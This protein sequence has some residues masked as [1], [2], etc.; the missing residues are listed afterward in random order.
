[1]KKDGGR[2][3]ER[4]RGREGVMEIYIVDTNHMK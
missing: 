1:M 2:D 3:K 4:T